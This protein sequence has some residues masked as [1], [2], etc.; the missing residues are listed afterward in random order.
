MPLT[1]IEQPILLCSLVFL[2]VQYDNDLLHGIYYNVYFMGLTIIK[3]T[4]R[5]VI[6]VMQ[7]GTSAFFILLLSGWPVIY[8]RKQV[9]ENGCP[10]SI[11]CSNKID[12]HDN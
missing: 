4:L 9:P 5:V 6:S 1:T 8:P 2:A 12:N 11:N 10:V 3:S 7:N